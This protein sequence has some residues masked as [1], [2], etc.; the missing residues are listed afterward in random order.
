MG[1]LITF[2]AILLGAMSVVCLAYS[3]N[4][5]L[6]TSEAKSAPV[7]I[8]QMTETTHSFIFREYTIE[9]QMQ[10]QD[11]EHK[12][13]TT[14]QHMDQFIVAAGTA[15]IREGRFGWPWVETIDPIMPNVPPEE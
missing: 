3:A 14:P 9:Y 4:A 15:Q 11:K 7:Q 12:L 13:M 10:G 5:M 1:L 2:G 6:D 8:M